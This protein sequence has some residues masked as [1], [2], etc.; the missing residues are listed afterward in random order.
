MGEFSPRR[1]DGVRVE[2]L[3]VEDMAGRPVLDAASLAVSPGEIRAVVGESGSGKTTL[4][5]ALL[6]RVRKGLTVKSG[7][8]SVFGKDA[9]KLKGKALRNY[10][11]NDVSWLSQDPALSLTPH[12]RVGELLREVSNA[13]LKSDIDQLLRSV[14]LNEVHGILRRKPWELSGGQRRRVAIARAVAA[15]PKL[16]VLDEPTAGLD[17]MAAQDVTRMI[18]GLRERSGMAVMV[19]THDLSFASKLADTITVIEKG[20]IVEEGACK[21]VLEA[22]R[23]CY[24]QELIRAQALSSCDKANQDDAS[25]PLLR[26]SDLTVTTPDGKTA[27]SAV[28]F[29]LHAGEGLAILGPSGAGKSTIVSALVGSRVADSGKIELCIGGNLE[30]LPLAR[31]DR[32]IESLL[33]MQVIPQDPAASLNPALSVDVQL[34]RAVSRRHP[35]WGNPRRNG[36]VVSL[37][38]LVGLNKGIL[39]A[40]PQALSG[41]QAQRIAIARSLAHE[42]CV[43]ICDESTSALDATTQKGVLD[44]LARLRDREGLALIVVTHSEQVASFLCSKT[45]MVGI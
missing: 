3:V 45:L 32:E 8:I 14:G 30:E 5:L 22:P 29:E 40:R 43:L 16:L 37:I 36:Q 24:A 34:D 33:S 15:R 25:L 44:V 13:E 12:M 27:A 6:G 39:S 28:S 41:G 2:G 42:P 26:V 4:A 1:N 10:R 38:E 7:E 21:A 9:L 31:E 19:I 20:K 35:D 23:S 11:R 17:A 18:V